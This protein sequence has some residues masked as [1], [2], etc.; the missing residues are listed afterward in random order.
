MPVFL[1]L[2][3]W[4]ALTLYR[5]R[6]L[7]KVSGL[8]ISSSHRRMHWYTLLLLILPVCRG[9]HHRELR[10]ILGDI[11]GSLYWPSVMSWVLC[12]SIL[13]NQLQRH[14]SLKMRYRCLRSSERV[15]I[16]TLALRRCYFVSNPAFL[17]PLWLQVI[18]KLIVMIIQIILGVLLLVRRIIVLSS[19]R[20]SM[21][22][23]IAS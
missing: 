9:L 22:N 6:L 11:W 19:V 8:V 17:G 15:R 2:L 3:S 13:L 10:I 14:V 16:D 4:F 20:T 23:L 5:G 7:A 18:I 21:S 12:R 1:L